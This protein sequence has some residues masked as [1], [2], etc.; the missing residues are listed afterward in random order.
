MKRRSQLVLVGIAY[1]SFIGLGMPSGL[2]G[3]AWPSI[4]STFGLSLDAIGSLLVAMTVGSL[5]SGFASGAIVSRTGAGRYFLFSSIAALLGLLGYAVA[6]TWW[7]LVVCGL[8]VGLAA[9]GLD[10]GLNTYF[11]V[12][13]SSRL[14]NWLHACFG[15]GAALGPVL[16]TII[17]NG[18]H[19]WR[20]GYAIVGALQALVA[21]S[22]AL[23]LERWPVLDAALEET[24]AGP[25][26]RSAKTLTSLR[27]PIIWASMILF[28]VSSGIE[29]S[30]G[31]WPYSLFTEARSVTPATAGFWISVFWGSLTAG[32]ILYGIAA[33]RLEVV[34]SLRVSMIAVICG[35]ALVWWN[36]TDLLSFLG[37]ALM[38]LALAPIFPLLQLVTPKRFGA[39]H[40]ANAIGFQTGAAYLGLGLMPGLAGVLAQSLGLEVIGPFL[41]VG[42]VVTFLVHEVIVSC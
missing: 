26:A 2:L 24:E 37:L 1:V 3:V 18:G 31:Q 7:A 19:S 15:L 12:K 23:T 35:A 17:I 42:A 40:A 33:D 38:G 21:L 28:F 34:A 16:M 13:L 4:R 9:G 5:L 11:A 14:M 41:L 22:F 32:R 30:A 20:W 25:P 10:A 6:P 39:E 36:V 29:I 27:L 8:L